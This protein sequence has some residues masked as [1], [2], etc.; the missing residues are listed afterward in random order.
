M[1]EQGRWLF[2]QAAKAVP[3]LP[4]PVPEGPSLAETLFKVALPIVAYVAIAPVLWLFFRRT[5]RELDVE[6][7]EHQRRTLAAGQYD[8]RPAVLFTIT[9]LVLTLQH[10]FGG[11]DFFGDHIKPW[12]RGVEL[13]QALHPGGLGQYVSLRKY[14]ELYS[15]G[16][17]TF[18]RVLGY[19]VIPFVTWK[20]CF[21]KDSLLDMGLRVRGLL[22]H[23]WI[24]GL[25]LAVVVPAVFIV[26][27]SPDF[28]NYYPFYKQSS[29]SWFDFMVWEAM[30]FLQFF[31]LEIFFRGFWLSGLRRTMGSG[32]IFA[33]IVPY[34]MIHFGKPYLETAG[35]VIAGIALGS[36]AMRTKSIYSGFIVHVTVALL[37]DVLSLMNR[38]AIPKVFWAP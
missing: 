15:Y 33:M 13:E 14:T 36:L 30:Y 31:A 26:A 28:G 16:W 9:A 1:L 3:P 37:M 19:V 17:W 4:L 22:S 35:A 23:A 11:R 20:I 8:Y 27:S 7:H 5:W 2:A 24:Y 10:Y 38:N 32:A 34:C 25:C 18:T 29:R 6:A 12:L 21:R